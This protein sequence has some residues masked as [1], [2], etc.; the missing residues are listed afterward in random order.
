MDRALETYA[1]A[2]DKPTQIELVK[3]MERVARD[4]M[5]GVLLYW[6]PKVI[7][8]SAQLKGIPKILTPEGQNQQRKIWSW[9]WAA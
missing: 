5:P 3:R 9:E 4:K 2:L 6:V 8:Y 1:T 7:A